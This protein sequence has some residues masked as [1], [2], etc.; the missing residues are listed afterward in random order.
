VLAYGV[1]RA[2]GPD[3]HATT[4]LPGRRPRLGPAPRAAPTPAS[5]G[6]P[7]LLKSS[8]EGRCWPVVAGAGQWVGRPF[9]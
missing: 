4:A 7:S 3:G 5:L 1:R 9:I 6:L 8:V 2:A